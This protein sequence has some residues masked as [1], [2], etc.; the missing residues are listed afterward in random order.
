MHGQPHIKSKTQSIVLS[1]AV[2]AARN[3]CSW[4]AYAPW[5]LLAAAN[6]I[7]DIVATSH[8]V[9]DALAAQVSPSE[10]SISRDWRF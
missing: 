4:F 8:Y 6:I 2:A 1:A 7:L 10:H 3:V 5:I 9:N